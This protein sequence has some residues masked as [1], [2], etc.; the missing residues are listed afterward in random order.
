MI[1]L[2]N[3]FREIVTGIMLFI[4]LTI[5]MLIVNTENWAYIMPI[6]L[7]GV[8]AALFVLSTFHCQNGTRITAVLLIIYVCTYIHWCYYAADLT[9]DKRMMMYRLGKCSS[10]IGRY[11]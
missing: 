6:T 3:T 1:V 4:C 10:C 9:Y 2:S 7:L 8:A 11:R 5:F